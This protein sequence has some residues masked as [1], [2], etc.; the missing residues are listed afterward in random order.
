MRRVV[1]CHQMPVMGRPRLDELVSTL[2]EKSFE[3]VNH[4][5]PRSCCVAFAHILPG[6]TRNRAL[7]RRP[8]RPCSSLP[9][10]IEK[11]EVE[12][13]RWRPIWLPCTRN[14]AFG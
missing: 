4:N 8:L 14:E 11:A 10:S 1:A 7:N 3:G 6:N 9:Y 5:F 2:A 12:R 13:A